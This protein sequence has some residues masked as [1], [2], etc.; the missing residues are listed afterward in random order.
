MT[1]ATASVPVCSGSRSPRWDLWKLTN[2][3]SQLLLIRW[4]M[5]TGKQF[6]YGAEIPTVALL[7]ASSKQAS[8]QIPLFVPSFYIWPTDLKMN[9]L[10]PCLLQQKKHS[11]LDFMM[12][13]SVTVPVP[14]PYKNCLICTQSHRKSP[15]NLNYELLFVYYVDIY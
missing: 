9:I 6:F 15:L 14:Q 4:T 12:Y 10:F 8:L 7:Q 3:T 5:L 11:P 1:T 2:S 13:H